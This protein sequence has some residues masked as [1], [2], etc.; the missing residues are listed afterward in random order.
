[1]TGLFTGKENPDISHYMML[2]LE[3]AKKA[4]AAGDVPVGAVLV[5]GGEVLACAHNMREQQN[6]PTAHAEIL[7]MREGAGKLGSW[8]LEGAALFVTK[9]PCPMCAGAMV[10]ARLG[11]LI[12]GCRDSKGGAA[13][14]LFDI[15]RDVRLNHR[16]EVV[17]G[18]MEDECVR[19]LK[20][21]F[22]AKRG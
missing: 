8:R 1:M 21:F 22:A 15:P 14:S 17:S 10:N 9:E 13:G 4:W 16:V 5:L 7:A 12:Y 11:R 18:V 6:D 2:A 3:E 20:G 19:L